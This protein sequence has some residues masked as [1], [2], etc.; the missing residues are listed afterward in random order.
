M[1]EKLRIHRQK[2]GRR[3]DDSQRKI[4]SDLV[5]MYLKAMRSPDGKYCPNPEVPEEER[6]YLEYS[7]PSLLLDALK[8]F[9]EHGTFVNPFNDSVNDLILRDQFDKLRAKKI[10]YQDA[11]A[12]LSEEHHTTGKTIERRV[13]PTKRAK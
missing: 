8:T 1:A 7:N 9:A 13:S 10:S 5:N 3:A 11:V 6:S 2:K 4:A 12:Q